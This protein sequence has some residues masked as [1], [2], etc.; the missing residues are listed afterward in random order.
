M[1]MTLTIDVLVFVIKAVMTM[2]VLPGKA[3][4]EMVAAIMAAFTGGQGVRKTAVH[5][6]TGIALVMGANTA[7][8][9]KEQMRMDAASLAVRVILEIQVIAMVA[10]AITGKT[11][12]VANAGRR[13]FTG[14][15]FTA[16]AAGWATVCGARA[17]TQ[18]RN[19]HGEMLPVF[20]KILSEDR[21]Y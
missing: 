16:A 2:V 15:A 7:L 11:V 10:V 20:A 1:K 13:M 17:P 21:G 19:S 18:G 12:E 3:F 9:E 5:A 8:T 6:V 4:V 14:A